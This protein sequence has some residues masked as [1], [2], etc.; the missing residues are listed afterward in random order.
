MASKVKGVVFSIAVA[1]CFVCLV[2]MAQS[3]VTTTAAAQTKKGSGSKTVAVSATQTRNL[4]MQNCARCH[5]ADGR[6]QT[7]QGE[8]YGAHDLTDAK[9][10]SKL[11]N[12]RVVNIITRGGGGM[13][14]F[15]KKLSKEEINALATFVRGFRADASR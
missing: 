11:S 2:N 14:A 6:G 10:M 12:K 1:I 4:Y 3:S 8:M 7:E 15:A 13:P 9:L 5:G